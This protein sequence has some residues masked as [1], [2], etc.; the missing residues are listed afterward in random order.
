MYDIEK[1]KEELKP[2]N[3]VSYLGIPYKKIGNNLF[4]FCPDHEERTGKADRHIGNCVLGKSFDDAYYCFGCG[5]R[6]NC[7][8][9]ISKAKNLDIKKEF[10]SVLT[11]AVQVCGGAD[12]YK[13]DSSEY[14]NKKENEKKKISSKLNFTKEQLSIIGLNQNVFGS[15][16]TEAYSKDLIK[17]DDIFEKDVNINHIDQLG[18]PSVLYVSSKR[19]SYSLSTLAEDDYEAYLFLLKNQ[20]MEAMNYYKN[21]ALKDYSDLIRS[22]PITIRKNGV[23]FSEK[24]KD[25]CKNLYLESENIYKEISGDV[26]IDDSWIYE[27]E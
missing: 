4:I 3:I 2:I 12:N 1:I 20:S 27:Y 21:L 6:G 24:I 22:L 16:Y 19:I 11:I 23:G 10:Y 14:N 15:T 8:D 26:I 13:I 9:L 5:A 17:D 18:F 7:F 25:Y